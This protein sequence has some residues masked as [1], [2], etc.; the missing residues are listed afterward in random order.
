METKEFLNRFLQN[1]DETGRFIVK[2]M[3]TGKTYVVECIDKSGRSADWGEIDPAT[4]TMT[5][6]YGSK[7]TGS[8]KPGDSMITEENGCINIELL[9]PGTSPYGEILKR[10]KEYENQM[11]NIIENNTCSG[12]TIG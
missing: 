8:V 7:Y 10:D 9:E 6:N 12:Q 11:K 3:V 5:G 2:S 1:S 4:K